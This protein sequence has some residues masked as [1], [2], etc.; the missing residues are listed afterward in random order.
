MIINYILVNNSIK[1]KFKILYFYIAGVVIDSLYVKCIKNGLVNI[2]KSYV[3]ITNSEMYLNNIY[4]KN[5][6]INCKLLLKKKQIFFFKNKIKNNFFIL[7]YG[8][9]MLNNKIKFHI[10]LC[11]K[12]VKYFN[13]NILLEKKIKYI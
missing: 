5:V 13:K 2:L 8:I 10:C 9:F 12:H 4:V 3:N 7:P 1:Y 11:I 6:K